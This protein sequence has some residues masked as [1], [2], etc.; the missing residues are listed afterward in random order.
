MFCSLT[1]GGTPPRVLIIDDGWQSVAAD[2]TM[3]RASATAVTQG[4]Q[5]ASRLVHIKENHKFQKN[6]KDGSWPADPCDGL[7]HFVEVAK[8]NYNLK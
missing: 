6:G 7:Q 4:T 8:Q 1:E 5:Y 2:E 3:A